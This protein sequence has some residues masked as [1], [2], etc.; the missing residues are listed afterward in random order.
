MTLRRYPFPFKA[1]LAICSDLDETPDHHTYWAMMQ[2]LNSR[3]VGPFGAGVGLE[4]GN[5]IY[6]DMPSNQFAYW[7]TGDEG[8]AMVRSLIQSGH[9][10]CLHSFGDLASDRHH[11]GRALDELTKHDCRLAVW[12]DHAIAP[13][14][15]GSDIMR[16]FGDVRG[17]RAY[18]A[19]LTSSYG[20][21]YVWRG[22]VTSVIGQ[23][24]PPS[25]QGIWNGHHPAASLK[26]LAKESV[27]RALAS[28]R[29]RYRPHRANRVISPARLRDGTATTEFLRCNP[30]WGGVSCCDTADGIA[31]VLTTSFLDR[32]VQRR[33]C[34]V[35]YTHLGK[36]HARNGGHFFGAATVER[37]RQ[38]AMRQARG[39]VL[40]TTTRR[41]LDYC[42][43]RDQLQVSV[44]K[45]ERGLCLDLTQPSACEQSEQGLTFYTNAPDAVEVRLNG[46]QLQDVVCN[47]A[48][49]TGRTS[50][51]I[52]W[53]S[54]QF[55][56][57]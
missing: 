36:R 30:H 18:H 47:A 8:R 24:Q 28:E 49:E 45:R 15:F 51:S 19:D 12:V 26:T 21:R 7:N 53:R 11:A 31:D 55:P 3:H 35:L 6:F 23:D 37:F 1:M 20:V 46:R 39:E 57:L 9:I 25:L 48:D 34:S 17:H 5:S 41:L 32:L 44:S 54:L 2:F 29:S 13:S 4:V 10:D 42:H 27:K 16:G 50:V 33:G 38:L 52:P 43:S 56:Q 22:R 40:V 14:N